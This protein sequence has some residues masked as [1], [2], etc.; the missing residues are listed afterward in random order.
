MSNE[1]IRDRCVDFI[2][3][4]LGI[5][6]IEYIGK[7]IQLIKEIRS[8]IKALQIIAERESE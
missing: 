3:R 8:R 2:A 7:P 4:D 6:P 1:T 5:N